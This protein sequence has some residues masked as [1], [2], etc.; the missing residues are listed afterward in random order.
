M[1]YKKQLHKVVKE[2]FNPNKVI[3]IQPYG[4]GLINSTFIVEFEDTRYILQKV[5]EYVFHSP[6]G[7]MYNI[8]LITNYIRKKVIYEGRNYR[9]ATLTLIQ[10]ICGENFAI[11]D[12]AYWRCYTCIDG[13]TYDSTND[14]E[15]FYEAGKAVGQFQQLLEGFHT[16]LLSCLLYTSPSP[17]D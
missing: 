17:R 1:D 10:T 7:V 12:E 3:S 4:G 6:I 8:G 15:I 5:N 16:R 2:Y 9:N 13:I 14:L 11:V